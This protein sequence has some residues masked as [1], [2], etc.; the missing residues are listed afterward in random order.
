MQDSVY[1][2]TLD[3]HL[4]Y[5]FT[6]KSYFFAVSKHNVVKDDTACYKPHINCI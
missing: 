6:V 3:R 5:D 4:I 1:H 2:M